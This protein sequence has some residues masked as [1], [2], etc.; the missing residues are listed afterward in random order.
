VSN[1][2]QISRNDVRPAFKRGCYTISFIRQKNTITRENTP[3]LQILDTLRYQKNIPDTSPN[4]IYK[5]LLALIQ[6][7]SP[8]QKKSL[9]ELALK[10][11]PSTRAFLGAALDDLGDKRLS[12]PLRESLNPIS[13]YKLPVAK[14]LKSAKKWN[15]K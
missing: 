14:T 4:T 7:L 8:K 10:Y 2:I 1:I 12:Q 6:D 13:T 11:P 15:I 3:L 9:I 5:R